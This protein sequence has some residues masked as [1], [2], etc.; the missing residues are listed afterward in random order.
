MT[1][2]NARFGGPGS[3]W[4]VRM[5]ALLA[6]LAVPMG[7]QAA[8]EGESGTNFA[9]TAKEG[10]ISTPE[11]GSIYSWGYTTGATMQLPGPTLLV[12]EGQTVT[13]TLTNALPLAGGNVSM[14]F[15]GL[16]VTAAGGQADGPGPGGRTTV[17]RMVTVAFDRNHD[18]RWCG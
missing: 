15:P 16:D 14:V 10:Y 5:G 1:A 9:I 4:A 8:V 13:I 17:T 12:T 18:R 2:N 3:R 11:G 6:L 7:A